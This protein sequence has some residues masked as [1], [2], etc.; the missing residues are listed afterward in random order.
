[1][2][3]NTPF[4]F[5]LSG[6]SDTLSWTDGVGEGAIKGQ[7]EELQENET[8]TYIALTWH[9]TLLKAALMYI[10]HSTSH[11]LLVRLIENKHPPL[12]PPQSLFFTTA[13]VLLAWLQ[14]TS[15]RGR[16]RNAM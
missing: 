6:S 7:R 1:M 15:V 11:D 2:I 12:P 9:F 16:R 8:C 5:L 13:P 14:L 10:N 4:V 3:K